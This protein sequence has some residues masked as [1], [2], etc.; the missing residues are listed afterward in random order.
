M[1]AE[2][3]NPTVTVDNFR[4]LTRDQRTAIGLDNDQRALLHLWGRQVHS[5]RVTEAQRAQGFSANNGDIYFNVLN[6]PTQFTPS[7]RALI[8][9]LS[10]A[11]MAKQGF[12]DG[13]ELDK[14]FFGLVDQLHGNPAGATAT[15]FANTR[16][17]QSTGQPLAIA[18]SLSELENRNGLSTFEQAVLRLWGHDPLTNGGTIDG[19]VIAYTV[20][21]AVSLD[22]ANNAGNINTID[23]EALQLLRA[24]FEIDGV[25]NG[26]SL[27]MAFDDLLEKLYP[28]GVNN[29]ADIETKFTQQI[30][31]A[32]AA[33]SA[34]TG[35]SVS[36]IAKNVSVGV[37][38]AVSQIHELVKSNPAGAI[39]SVGGLAIATAV[40][41]FLGGTLAAGGVIAMSNKVS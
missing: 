14:A 38:Q 40:C 33:R 21:N 36:Q 23:D 24:D 27:V 10:D 16:H 6:N 3:N 4:D 20:G 12:I 35:L 8:Q 37:Q 25:R 34:Q 15:K 28:Q 30:D 26:D 9:R 22:G 17:L 2:L 19:S 32:V 29:Q 13:S 1:Q 5:S 18:N 31:Q 11:E 7:E 41:P 39:A